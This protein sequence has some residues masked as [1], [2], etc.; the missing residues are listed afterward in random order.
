M[1]WVVLEFLLRATTRIAPESS[2]RDLFFLF[3][4]AAPF[5][6][7]GKDYRLYRLLSMNALSCDLVSAPTLVA[8]TLPFLNSIS[9]GMP[10]TP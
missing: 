3:S 7:S 5:E 2:T 4:G 10:R 1:C 9:V 6:P 8:S